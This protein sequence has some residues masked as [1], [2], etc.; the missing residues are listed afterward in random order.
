[1]R[2]KRWLYFALGV[3]TVL[4]MGAVTNQIA[5][6]ST[7]T[8]ALGE[9]GI[10]FPDGSV[11]TTAASPGTAAVTFYCSASAEKGIKVQVECRRADDDSAFTQVPGGQYLLVSDM[12]LYSPAGSFRVSVGKDDSG[13]TGTV[14]P[15]VEVF[16][17]GTPAQT[18]RSFRAPH[19]AL[20]AGEVLAL[21]NTGTSTGTVTVHLSGFLAPAVTHHL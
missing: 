20:A 7:E 1:M 6:L 12:T 13:G 5:P 19:I 18:H 14:E 10:T 11:Q 21:R 3:S 15:T 17:E 9:Q 8:L 2:E 16:G 4:G